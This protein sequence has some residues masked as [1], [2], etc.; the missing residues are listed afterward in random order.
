MIVSTVHWQRRVED[1]IIAEDR[2]RH[3]EVAGWTE[4]SLTAIS[5]G[6]YFDKRDLISV[7]RP[8]IPIKQRECLTSFE[9]GLAHNRK[10]HYNSLEL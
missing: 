10:F 7:Y 3:V 8:K 6:T 9:E 5:V 4:N 1:V 2:Y